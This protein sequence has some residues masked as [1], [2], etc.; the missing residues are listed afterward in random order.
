[1]ITAKGLVKISLKTFKFEARGDNPFD[2]T[3][4]SP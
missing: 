4:A 2:S 3:E 1:M